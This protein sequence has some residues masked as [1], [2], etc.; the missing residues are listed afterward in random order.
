MSE[1]DEDIHLAMHREA[2]ELGKFATQLRVHAPASLSRE[3]AASV[4]GEL[5]SL[6]TKKCMDHGADLVGHIKVF[7]KTADGAMSASLIDP[8]R[9]PNV[10]HDFGEGARFQDAEMTLH[11]IVHGI[12]DPEVREQS[13]E[14]IQAVFGRH[15]V[16][17][18]IIKDY[19]EK[20]K[21]MAHHQ[22]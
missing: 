4:L 2:D 13:L 22:K 15:G 1:M 11:V 8:E 6:I 19:Y 12:W 14:A 5:L 7:L 3:Q 20:D 10:T 17:Y 16:S 21:G 18:E 9:G